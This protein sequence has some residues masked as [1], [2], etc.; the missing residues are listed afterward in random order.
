VRAPDDLDAKERQVFLVTGAT[1]N[2]GAE[3]VS[4]LVAAA[5]D[6]RA[7]VRSDRPSGL[8]AGVEA[9]A[10]DLNRPTSL[11][12]ALAG[13]RGLFLLPGYADAFR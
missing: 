6:V 2:V 1:G 10:G 12:D 7:L 5:H 9:V 11:T 13:V 8:P 3:V 4:A